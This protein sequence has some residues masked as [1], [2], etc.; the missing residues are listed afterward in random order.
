MEGSSYVDIF[1]TKGPEYLLVLFFLV[2]LV[3]FWRTLS[4][5]SPVAAG[6]V[7]GGRAPMQPEWFHLEEG[8]FYHQ[9]HTWALPQEDE[10]VRVGV[11]D[12]AQ[13]LVGKVGSIELPRIGASLKQGDTGW[14]LH[15]AAQDVAMLSPVSGEVLA[16]NEEVVKDPQ[17]LSEDPYGKGWLLAVRIADMRSDLRNLLSGRLAGAW[18]RE[19]VDALRERMAGQLGMV[20]QDGG[21]PVQGF[22]Q[23]LSPDRWEEVAAEFLMTSQRPMNPPP[24]T[25]GPRGVDAAVGHMTPHRRDGGGE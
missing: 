24:R 16:V 6:E 4:A 13:K 23:H 15:V 11:D 2:V 17:L 5:R 8:R 1:A 18:M 22:A 25:S 21:D 19:T 3:L 10:V 14:A 7:A 9:G 12:F 20:M